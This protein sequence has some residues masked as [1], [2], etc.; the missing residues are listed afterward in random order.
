MKKYA[1]R[2]DH[3]GADL[4]RGSTEGQTRRMFEAG[5]ARMH[6]KYMIEMSFRYPIMYLLWYRWWIPSLLHEDERKRLSEWIDYSRKYEY[7][8]YWAEFSAHHPILFVWVL[9]ILIVVKFLSAPIKIIGRCFKC[10][11]VKNS[12]EDIEVENVFIE[13]NRDMPLEEIG[14]MR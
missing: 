13:Q 6:A 4:S 1:K 9:F 11:S 10:R 14:I 2:T 7:R 3:Q 5:T 12:S 8:P